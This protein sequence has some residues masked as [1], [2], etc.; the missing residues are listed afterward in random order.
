MC[1]LWCFTIR[2]LLNALQIKAPGSGTARLP[3]ERHVSEGL[4]SQQRHCEN[5]KS[6]KGDG[7]D[8]CNFNTCIIYVMTVPS[9][10]Q[11]QSQREY[12]E[13]HTK[14]KQEQT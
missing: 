3:K 6:H 10:D 2:G 9:D 13:H 12:T 11:L 7:D 8:N 1:G 4:N 14:W 5:L